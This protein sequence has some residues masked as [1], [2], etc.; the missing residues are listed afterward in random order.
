MATTSAAPASVSTEI[1]AIEKKIGL[2]FDPAHI[3]L[4]VLLAVALFTGVYLF[5]SREVKVAEGKAAVAT[6]VAKQAADDAKVSAVANAQLQAQ[7]DADIAALQAANAQLSQANAQQAAA[8]KAEAAALVKQQAVDKTM[9]PTQQSARWQQLVPTAEVGV[10]P[11]GGF[12]IN[13]QGGVDTLLQLEQVPV[14]TSAN[15]KLTTSLANDDLTIA[16]DAT[17]LQDEKD[18]HISDV[19]NDGK[20]LV[21]SQKETGKVQADF[22]VYKKKARKRY[23]IFFGAGYVAGLATKHF[24]GL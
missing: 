14:L 16:H 9:T 23:L 2:F 19:T 24:L 20:A 18:K 17:I 3:I 6:A 22:D 13:A 12:S 21:A 5:E 10:L 8:L 1:A 7:K 15:A 11:T 4:I